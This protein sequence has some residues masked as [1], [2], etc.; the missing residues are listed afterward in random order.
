MGI[1]QNFS[2]EA[3][4]R[5]LLTGWGFTTGYQVELM[6]ASEGYDYEKQP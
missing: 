1:A 3:T 5:P 4:D 2:C 6:G